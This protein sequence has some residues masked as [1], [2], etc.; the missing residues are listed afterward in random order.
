[1]IAS[2]GKGLARVD[3]AVNGNRGFLA[4]GNGVDDKL[5][6][7]DRVAARKHI[8]HLRLAGDGIGRNQ[9]VLS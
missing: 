7:G 6:P 8:R 3:K 2:Q 4:G 9:S 5:R 1:M